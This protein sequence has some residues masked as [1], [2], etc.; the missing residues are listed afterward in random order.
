LVPLG[1]KPRAHS[2][3]LIDG[4]VRLRKH[5]KAIREFGRLAAVFG[6]TGRSV[7]VDLAAHHGG[8]ASRRSGR[9]EGY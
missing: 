3:E 6:E 4:K 9:P 2:P 8:R 7:I 1:Q 5:N